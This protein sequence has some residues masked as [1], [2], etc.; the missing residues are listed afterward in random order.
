MDDHNE[1]YEIGLTAP[2]EMAEEYRL[3]EMLP[4]MGL[5]IGKRCIILIS[6]SVNAEEVLD[7][8]LHFGELGV[9]VLVLSEVS[10]GDGVAAVVVDGAFVALASAVSPPGVAVESGGVHM[11]ADH[12]DY[13]L[14]AVFVGFGAEGCELGSCAVAVSLVVAHLEVVWEVSVKPF[15]TVAA[16]ALHGTHLHGAEAG[17]GDTWKFCLDVGE[18]PVEAMQYISL[19]DV[20]GE[21]GGKGRH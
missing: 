21:L 4:M 7:A 20:R 6:N 16:V 10:V 3:D 2:M 12:I 13:N 8:L 9:D 15:G 5:K 19:L 11:V 17:G 14:D 18:F 1:M